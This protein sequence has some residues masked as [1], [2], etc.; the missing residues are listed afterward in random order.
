MSAYLRD[1]GGKIELAV[2][3]NGKVVSLRSVLYVCVAVE[4]RRALRDAPL[5]ELHGMKIFSEIGEIALVVL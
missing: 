5:G 1:N 4:V 2:M 3:H